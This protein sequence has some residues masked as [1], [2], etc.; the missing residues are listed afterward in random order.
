MKPASQ[1]IVP[2]NG[3]L[4]L[5]C[6]VSGAPPPAVYWLKNGQPIREAPSDM[7]EATNRIIETE[8]I[9]PT[10]GLASTRARLI[11]DCVDGDAEAIYTCVAESLTEKIIASTFVHVEGKLIR[12]LFHQ[13]FISFHTDLKLLLGEDPYN[14]TVCSLKH[15]TD[16][17]PA[18]IYMSSGTYIDMEGKDAVLL[19]RATGNPAPTVSWYDNEEKLITSGREFQV[20]PTGDLKIHNLSW[21][22]HMG[23]FKCQAENQFGQAEAS[24]FVYPVVVSL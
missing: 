12:P 11:I 5:A 17:L 21:I 14:E 2:L 4:E 10:R 13:Q 9:L 6:D 15:E 16:L 8:S 18:T 24:T 7:E 3:R 23:L 19:C 22:S 1:T 20:L